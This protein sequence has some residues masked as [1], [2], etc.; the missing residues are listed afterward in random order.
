[1]HRSHRCLDF[2]DKHLRRKA[3]S[4]TFDRIPTEQELDAAAAAAA[5]RR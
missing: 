3:S 1:M 5:G 4:R 2:F